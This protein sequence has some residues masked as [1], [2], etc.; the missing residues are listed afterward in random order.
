MSLPPFH[1]PKL[2]QLAILPALLMV[3]VYKWGVSPV[4]HALFPE[5]GCRYY[6]TCSDYAAEAFKRHG[7]VT[8]LWL[9]GRRVMRCNPWSAG[10]IDPVPL[11]CDAQ[12]SATT[13]HLSVSSH[14]I[15][16]AASIRGDSCSQ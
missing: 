5:A 6:P 8:G 9:A 7:L 11:C 16:G 4:I 3:R 13:S 1:A 2:K 12:M 10:G 14:N 15:Q